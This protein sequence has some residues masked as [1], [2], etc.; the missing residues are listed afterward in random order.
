MYMGMLPLCK[1]SF[2]GRG[3]FRHHSLQTEITK[4]MGHFQVHV[5]RRSRLC[6][7]TGLM[8]R[9]GPCLFPSLLAFSQG[10]PRRMRCRNTTHEKRPRSVVLF[11]SL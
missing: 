3:L 9:A 1:I 4:Y 5:A 11:C 7:I 8:D 2:P 10:Y 6:E